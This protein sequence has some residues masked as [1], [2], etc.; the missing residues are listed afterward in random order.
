M[1]AY[2][3][4]VNEFFMFVLPHETI[5]LYKQGEGKW[6]RGPQCFFQDC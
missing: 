4:Y 6:M 2:V 1:Y 3:M 5:L